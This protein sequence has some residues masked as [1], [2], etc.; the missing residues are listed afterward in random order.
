MF[1]TSE[2]SAVSLPFTTDKNVYMKFKDSNNLKQVADFITCIKIKN[3][4]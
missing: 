3:H 1:V 4:S 2:K